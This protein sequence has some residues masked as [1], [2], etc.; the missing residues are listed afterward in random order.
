MGWPGVVYS[1]ILLG[2]PSRD[3]LNELF[4]DCVLMGLVETK[5]ERQPWKLLT[6]DA[7]NTR[8][9]VWALLDLFFHCGAGDP[10]RNQTIFSRTQITSIQISVHV[11]INYPAF[12]APETS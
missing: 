4:V 6:R 9:C 3:F 2:R 12:C 10:P 7:S 8:V 1:L 5:T 11:P